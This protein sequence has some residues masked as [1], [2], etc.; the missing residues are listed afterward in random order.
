MRVASKRRHRTVATAGA[1][2]CAAV[3]VVITVLSPQALQAARLQL[4][5]DGVQQS[6]PATDQAKP[7]ESKPGGTRPTNPAPEPAHPDPEAQKQGAKAALPLAP[8]EK[9]APPIKDKQ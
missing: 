4:A 2:A 8:A 9:I 7:A 1:L 5:A 3:L 6:T